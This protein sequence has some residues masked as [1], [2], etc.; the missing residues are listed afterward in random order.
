M[1]ARNET[2][3]PPLESVNKPHLTTREAGHYLNRSAQTLRIWKSSGA[4][5][6]QPITIGGRLAWPT[7]KLK[8]LLGIATTTEPTGQPKPR[9]TRLTVVAGAAA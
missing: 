8:E 2:I 4:G 5:L 1:A 9:A 3:Y 6:L 7:D